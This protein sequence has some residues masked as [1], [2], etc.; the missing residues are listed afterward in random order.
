MDKIEYKDVIAL[1]FK[2][3]TTPTDEVFYNRYGFNYF[4]VSKKLGKIYSMDWD[5]INHTINVYKNHKIFKSKL[6]ISEVKEY[7]NLLK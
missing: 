4:I 6:T 5:I 7:I 2:K 1:G 3:D